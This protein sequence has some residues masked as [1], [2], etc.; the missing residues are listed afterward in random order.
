MYLTVPRTTQSEQVHIEL[1]ILF[2]TI[3]DKSLLIMC[4]I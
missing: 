1:L 3:D 4:F 2:N